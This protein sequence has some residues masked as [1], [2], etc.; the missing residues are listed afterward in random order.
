MRAWHARKHEACIRACVHAYA[1]S[2]RLP[3][4]AER[5]V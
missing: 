1:S 4:L 2:R 3:R 5:R